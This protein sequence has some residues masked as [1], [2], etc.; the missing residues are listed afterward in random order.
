M[1]QSSIF[2]TT[3]ATLTNTEIQL[4]ETTGAIGAALGSGFGAEIY[5]DYS[6]VFSN[7][8]ISKTY[9]PDLQQKDQYLDA[10][11]TWLSYLKLNESK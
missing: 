1:F 7:E 10:Y 9:Y 5:S 3:I 2:S 4:K 11:S 8:K 6:S